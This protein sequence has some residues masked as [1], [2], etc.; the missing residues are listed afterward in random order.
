MNIKKC[1]DVLSALKQG[2]ELE[3]RF[4]GDE[5]WKQKLFYAQ[6]C[7]DSIPV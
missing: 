5:V 2:M 4:K 3:W 7:D 6:I 1:V